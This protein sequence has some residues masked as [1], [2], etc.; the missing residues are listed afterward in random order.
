LFQR[1]ILLP[2]TQKPKKYDRHSIKRTFDLHVLLLKIQ[3]S[4]IISSEKLSLPLN[5]DN[6]M[7]PF[8]DKQYY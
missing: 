1:D 7:K 5:E 2:A 3:R 8:T 6:G 4:V